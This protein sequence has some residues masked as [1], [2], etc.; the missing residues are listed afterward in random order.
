MMRDI[1]KPHRIVFF[2][3]GASR[4]GLGRLNRLGLQLAVLLPPSTADAHRSLP[5]GR[6]PMGNFGNFRS[7]F[8]QKLWVEKNGYP[9]FENGVVFFFPNSNGDLEGRPYFQ[10]LQMRFLSFFY[11]SCSFEIYML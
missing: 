7:V 4:T 8:G 6:P 9:Q 1:L 3:A 5:P 2:V 10:T 11:R